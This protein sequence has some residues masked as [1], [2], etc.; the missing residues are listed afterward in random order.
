MENDSRLSDEPQNTLP[1]EEFVQL[2]AIHR[3]SLGI[4]ISIGAVIVVIALI[5]TIVHIHTNAATTSIPSSDVTSVVQLRVTMTAATVIL[6]PTTVAPLPGWV[7]AGLNNMQSFDFGMSQPAIGY[8]CGIIGQ[9]GFDNLNPKSAPVLLGM[10]T[11]IGKTWTMTTL[12]F[13]AA[14]CK[15]SIDPANARH[16]AILTSNCQVSCSTSNVSY[17]MVHESTD[18]GLTW[19][20]YSSYD[21]NGVQ[22][23]YS[24]DL[25]WLNGTLLINM[26]GDNGSSTLVADTA[27]AI[28]TA[29][30]KY[31]WF[32]NSGRLYSWRFEN[33]SGGV[34]VNII[35]TGGYTDDFGVSW[36]T[37]PLAYQGHPIEIIG[38]GNTKQTIFATSFIS[39]GPTTNPLLP[40]PLLISTNSGI[41]WREAP[42][43]AGVDFFQKGLG[44]YAPVQTPDGTLIIEVPSKSSNSN[45][46]FL[47]TIYRLRSGAAVWEDVGTITNDLL[48]LSVTWDNNGHPLALW[49]SLGGQETITTGPKAGITLTTRALGMQMLVLPH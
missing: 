33:N 9:S 22:N 31:S 37:F 8:A 46:S 7:S 27:N 2:P 45:N 42:A 4:L 15:L 23:H 29:Q 21:R 49:C 41:S 16:L 18:S 38:T 35:V 39:D 17:D 11:N 30:F 13:S 32:A 24:S 43:I 47:Y 1:T 28:P 10:T 40:M 48:P 6:A 44:I 3:R 19:K 34:P 5:I 14:F 25:Y 12:S 20:H 36:T 26:I